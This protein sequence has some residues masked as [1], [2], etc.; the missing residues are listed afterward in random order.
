MFEGLITALEVAIAGCEGEYTVARVSSI[1]TAAAKE[2]SQ[3]EV[4]GEG[5]PWGRYLV[6][7]DPGGLFNIQLDIFSEGY[8]G[9]IHA[10]ETW[11]M[12]WVLKG[13]LRFWDYAVDEAGP[14]LQ[15]HGILAPGSGQC[16]CPPVSDWHQVGDLGTGVQ[17]VSIHIYG[18]GFD[19]DRGMGLDDQGAI[20]HYARGRFRDLNDVRDAL[21]RRHPTG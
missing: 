8:Q 9:T 21:H 15:R 12:L 14:S 3:L 10:H 19:L 7:K 11:G 6:H 2:L 5:L 13:G 17:P 4:R 1:F 16:F 18:K 20:I